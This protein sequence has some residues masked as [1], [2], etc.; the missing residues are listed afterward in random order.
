[1]LYLKQSTASQDVLIGPFVD[2]SDG[3]TAETGL[4]IANTDIRLSKNGG[5]LASKNSGGGTHDEA[6][7]YQITL[8]ATDTNTVGTLQLHVK[9]SGALMVHHEFTVLEEDVYDALIGSG[10]AAFDSNQRVDV[11]SWLGTAVTLS[12]TTSKPQVDVDSIDDDA[13]AADNAEQFFDDTGFNASNSTIGTVS[14]NSDKTGYRLSATGVDDVLDEVYEGTTTLRQF[15]RLAA[16]A[17]WGKLSGAATT[18]VLI[19]DEAD[20]TNRIDA[21]VDSDGNRTAVTLDKS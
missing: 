13:T 3:A 1:M 21:T 4:T 14:T 9:V 5:N 8:D 20:S 19:R 12:G 10:A 17:L 18:N 2:D 6:G 7:W 15:L 16:S 11:G